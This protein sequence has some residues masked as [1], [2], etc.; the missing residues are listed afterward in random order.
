MS[1]ACVL[2]YC[3]ADFGLYVLARLGLLFP[4]GYWQR[5]HEGAHEAL[6]LL[7]FGFGFRVDLL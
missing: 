2:V 7:V 6:L 5:T 3:M 4:T 1:M